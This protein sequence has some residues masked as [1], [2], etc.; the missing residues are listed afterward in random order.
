MA[1]ALDYE[2]FKHKIK[3]K[4]GLDLSHY[5]EQQMRRRIH[6]LM[7]RYKAADYDTFMRMLNDDGDIL[8][9]F[10]DYLTINTSQFFRDPVIYRALEMQLLPE[11][12][13]GG[14]PLKVWSAGCS[15]GAEPYSLAMLLSEQDPG[16]SWR[17]LATDF[18]VNILAKAKEGK[19]PDN[20]LTHVPERFRKRYFNE[21][22]GLFFLDSQ[23]KNRVQFR[24]QNLLTDRYE[25]GCNLILCRNVFIYFTVE[26]QENLID[27]FTQG[28]QAG[29]FFIIGCSEMITNPARFGLQ[30]VKP[31]IY[32]KVK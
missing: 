12:L 20:L 29:G 26:T 24:R 8:R 19:Y 14:K 28:L 3:A 17:V 9:H 7:Q 31:A 30:K 23:I 2:G 1:L 16:C 5:K 18:D 10:T 15:V 22:D 27:R 25:I 11:L 13:Q 4:I 6:Q 32:R 21:R